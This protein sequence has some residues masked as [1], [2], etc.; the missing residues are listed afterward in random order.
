MKDKLHF[1]INGAWVEPDSSEKIQ[2]INPALIIIFIPLFSWVLYP[3]I[4][5]FFPLTPLRKIGIGFFL[6]VPLKKVLYTRMFLVKT[7]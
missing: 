7:H 4:N 3:A 1:Y 6:V 2:A 5:R